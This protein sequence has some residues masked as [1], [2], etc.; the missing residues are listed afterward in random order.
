MGKRLLKGA[1][2]SS[3]EK[4]SP[5]WGTHNTA[6]VELSAGPAGSLPIPVGGWVSPFIIAA[7]I[8]LMGF[9]NLRASEFPEPCK[10]SLLP[11][12]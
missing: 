7:E 6:S 9:K 11:K 12:S 8:T 5:A 1:H 10:F 3:I 4:P 2:S